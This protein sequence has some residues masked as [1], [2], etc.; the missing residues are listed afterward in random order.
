MRKY[1]LAGMIVGLFLVSCQRKAAVLQTED[2]VVA[3][4]TLFS[5]Q[6]M[7][8]I[9]HEVSSF[10]A[11]GDTAAYWIT[12]SSGRLDSLYRRVAGVNAVPYAGVYAELKVFNRGAS[13]E[14]FAADYAGVYEVAEI[15]KVESMKLHP[16]CR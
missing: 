11:C 10:V 8:S 15:A 1:F 2:A 16:E 13:A 4:D 14:G 7:V 6:G 3:G 9:G 5:V 12:D